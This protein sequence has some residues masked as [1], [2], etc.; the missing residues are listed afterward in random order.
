MMK[1]EEDFH[2]FFTFFIYQMGNCKYN[3]NIGEQIWTQ[4]PKRPPAIS[5]RKLP[6]IDIIIIITLK[7]SQVVKLQNC[8]FN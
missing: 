2:I 5:K 6:D 7:N 3:Y 1:K 4:K 8:Q